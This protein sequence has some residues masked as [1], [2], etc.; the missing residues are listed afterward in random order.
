[1][2]KL[3]PSYSEALH[4]GSSSY[5]VDV[6][7][8]SPDLIPRSVSFALW[9]RLPPARA[10]P[11]GAAAR[12][13]MT[14]RQPVTR[15]FLP[16]PPSGEEFFRDSLTSLIV[17]REEALI[18]YNVPSSPTHL[19]GPSLLRSRVAREEFPWATITFVARS[20][21][22]GCWDDWVDYDF[23]NDPPFVEV[24]TKEGIA[25][26]I[27]MSPRLSVYKRGEDLEFLLQRWSCVTHTFFA[28]WG[29]FTPT[30]EDIHVLMKL[31][32][33]GDYN[34]CESS[35]E[36]HIVEMAKELKVAT[37]ESAKYS[38]E[39]LAQ[40]RATLVSSIGSLSKTPPSKVR[41]TGNVLPPH[42]RKVAKGSLKYTYAT[43]IRYFFGDYDAHKVFFSGPS[44]PQPLKRV[45]FIAF[46]LSR[47]V[48][49][50]PPWESIRF[51]T[52][53][54]LH[55]GVSPSILSLT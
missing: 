3:H 40:H 41:G 20:T 8:S 12:K 52:K 35:I 18:F 32:M 49:P 29:E 33:F 25:D 45:A 13:W 47:Y 24:L 48:F 17:C 11:V 44:L 51:R 34:V 53:C 10:S 37:I 38:R 31:P 19:V 14:E 39:F 7:D 43:W 46:W 5:D 36:S 22:T 1:M 23:A 26:A 2:V 16:G 42:Q 30:L 55:L 15:P 6:E 21:L 27:R 54:C 4:E 9:T 28:S 50:G